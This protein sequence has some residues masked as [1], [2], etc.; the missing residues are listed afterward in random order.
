VANLLIA[1]AHSAKKL[2]VPVR[3]SRAKGVDQHEQFDEKLR[4]YHKS[5][6]QK[7]PAAFLSTTAAAA[8]NAAAAAS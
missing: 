2:L 5:R 7:I 3:R 6:G 4:E 8:E 1:I